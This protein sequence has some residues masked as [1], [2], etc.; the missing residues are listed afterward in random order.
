MKILLGVTGSV[1]TTLVLKIVS[2]LKKENH[3]VQIVATNSSLYFFKKR[4]LIQK[5]IKQYIGFK[6]DVP[7]WLDF[8]EWRG[9][10]YKKNQEIKH[11][12]LRKWADLFLIAPITANTLGKMANGL[13][14]NLLTSTIRAWDSQK[15]IIIAPAM[16]THMREHLMTKAHLESLK[17][18][19]QNIQIVEPI[20]KR[21]A[22]GDMGKGAMANIED[23][24]KIIK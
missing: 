16:N 6:V 12:E 13:A 15:P 4:W 2:E 1:A 24:V 18:L 14:D 17:N 23:I 9:F 5:L 3:E 21:L 8:H 7:L 11:I 20:E 19:Y 22:C 10:G